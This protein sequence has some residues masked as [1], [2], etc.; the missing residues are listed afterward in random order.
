MAIRL[1][2]GGQVV[3]LTTAQYE[4]LT[5]IARLTHDR[6][7]RPFLPGDLFPHRNNQDNGRRRTCA[8]LHRKA[9][10]ERRPQGYLVA[11]AIRWQ[12]PL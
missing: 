12:L 10:L 3:S 2:I 11:A 8:A 4:T 1:H 9:L 6:P 5:R 7:E